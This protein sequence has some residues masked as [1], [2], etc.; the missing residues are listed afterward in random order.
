[1]ETKALDEKTKDSKEGA[2]IEEMIKAGIHFG[3]IKSKRHPK[4]GPFIF[5]VR[6]NISIINVQKTFEQLKKA[7][8][9]LN[10]VIGK[11]GKIIFVNTKPETRNVVKELAEELGQPY[12]SERWLGGTLTNFKTLSS[13]LN[14]FEDL[15]KRKAEGALNKYTKKEQLDFEKEIKDLEK[16]F[17]GLRGLRQLPQAVFIVDIVTH[18][19]SLKEAQ[20]MNIPVVAVVD[21]NANPEEVTI[22]IPANDDTFSSVSWII[23]KIRQELAGA[24]QSSKEEKKEDEDTKPTGD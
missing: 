20:K 13:R 18:S 12:I 5:G 24:D 16:K 11:N 23:N 10:G 4:M 7:A 6:N 17:S 15:L 3:H 1:M 9:F 21:T 14:Y 2:L 19:T 8:E 22:A